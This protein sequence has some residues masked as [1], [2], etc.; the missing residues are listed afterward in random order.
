MTPSGVMTSSEIDAMC[1]WLD[2]RMKELTE[3]F[4]DKFKEK[5]NKEKEKSPFHEY[6][7][8][9]YGPEEGPGEYRSIAGYHRRREDW[10]AALK[11]ALECFLSTDMLWHEVV[12]HGIEKRKEDNEPT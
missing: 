1:K 2:R 9:N 3:E 6:M 4:V 10:N 11:W 12:E 7:I 8:S 5:E